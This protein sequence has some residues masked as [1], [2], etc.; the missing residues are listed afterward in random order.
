[1]E[2]EVNLDAEN[3]LQK[4]Q[5]IRPICTS[6][7]TFVLVKPSPS[8]P[9]SPSISPLKLPR[10]IPSNE[11]DKRK[12]LE[13]IERRRIRMKRRELINLTNE[14]VNNVNNENNNKHKNNGENISI[15]GDELREK[16][17]M[18][19]SIVCSSILVLPPNANP[20]GNTFGGQVSLYYLIS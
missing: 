6:F 19:Q 13:A 17:P 20:S 10:F 8:S 16:K 5:T 12:Y 9:Q 2:V 1:M 7:F 14:L 11:E 4:T 18:S 15:E 3:L